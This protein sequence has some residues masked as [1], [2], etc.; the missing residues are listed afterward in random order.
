MSKL[1]NGKGS[2]KLGEKETT[3]TQELE[4]LITI[5]SWYF[6]SCGLSQGRMEK[7]R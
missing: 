6:F 2:N 3:G 7:A 5:C 4:V 1:R